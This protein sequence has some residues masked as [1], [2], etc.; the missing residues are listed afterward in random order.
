MH[1]LPTYA[2]VLAKRSS[3]VTHGENIYSSALYNSHSFKDNHGY[4]GTYFELG[5][6]NMKACNVDSKIY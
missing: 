3:N 4:T 1:N 6:E 2:A 5:E